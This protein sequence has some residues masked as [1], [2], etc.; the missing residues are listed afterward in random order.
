MR[1]R[2]SEILRGSVRAEVSGAAPQRLLNAMS[3]ADMPFWDAVPQDAFTIRLG[4][5]SRDL[6]D[7]KALATRCQCELKLLRESGAPVVKRRLRRRVALLVTAVSCFALLAA[8]SLF[9]WDIRVEGNEQV[10]T[11]EILRALAGCGVESGSFWP[12]WSADEIRNSVILDIPELSWVGVSVDSSRALVRVRERTEAPSLVSEDGAGSVTAAATGIIERME[13]YQ[14][15]PVAAVGDAVVAGETLVSGEMPSEVGD[16]RY[17]R[18]SAVVEARTWYERSISAPMEYTAL[19]EA[20]TRSRW[21]L[22]VGGT[23]LNF[24]KRSSQTPAGCG[25]IVKEFPLAVEGVFTLPVTL[26]REQIVEYDAAP[27]R[28]DADALSAELSAQLEDALERELQGRGEVLNA[29]FTSSVSGERLIVTMRA[30]CREDI[31]VFTPA[32][33]A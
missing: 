21:Y 33:Q 10:S 5:Y 4:L 15:L 7:A 31:A 20:G 2:L 1:P 13:V 14:G 12:G 32:E 28:R 30:E 3:E 17:V 29:T 9:A 24:Y 25:K 6:R 23:R 19:E 18:A 11:G 27:A 8:S 22:T 16:T 26:V